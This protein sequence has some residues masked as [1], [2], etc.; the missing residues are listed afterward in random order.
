ML[1]TWTNH[2]FISISNQIVDF[3]QVNFQQTFPHKKTELEG[4]SF[5]CLIIFYAYSKNV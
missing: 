3:K 5:L 2:K 1:D 4:A